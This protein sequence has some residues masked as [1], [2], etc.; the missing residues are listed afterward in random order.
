MANVLIA[1]LGESPV[2]VTAMYNLLTTDEKEREIG[3]IDKVVV[4]Y[5]EGDMIELGYD[6]VEEAFKGRCELEPWMLP[7]ED[8]NSEDTSYAFLR[9]LFQLLQVQQEC[10]NTVYLS[11]AGGRKNMSALMALVIPFFSCVKKLYHVIDQYEHKAGYAFKSIENL[12]ELN[13]TDRKLYLIPELNHLTLVDIPY[14]EHQHISNELRSRILTITEAQL[15]DLWEENVDEAEVLQ[16]YGSLT[17]NGTSKKAQPGKNLVGKILEV[18]V[19]EHVEKEYQKIC[20][21]DALRARK[22]ATCF[23][24]M[25]FADRFA[26]QFSTH[27]K[28]RDQTTLFHYYKRG[29][30]VERP[31]YHTEPEGIHRYP[32]ADVRR[33]IIS[34]LA[35]EV[36]DK[37]EPSEDVLRGLP[38]IPLVSIDALLPTECILLVPLGASPM[39]AT[40]LYTLLTSQ[41]NTVEEVILIYPEQSRAVNNSAGIARKAFADRGVKCRDVQVKGYDDLASTNACL[42]Y[43]KVLEATI[44]D[45]R[46][47]YPNYQIELSLSGGRKGMSALAMFAAQRKEIHYVYHTL[48]NDDELNRRIDY[49]TSIEALNKANKHV[50]NDRLFLRAYAKSDEELH[51]KF[52]LFKVPVLPVVK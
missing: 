4:L 17:K 21:R 9:L 8:A 51:E 20:G 38:L 36:E 31:F 28:I 50:R 44:D 11:L 40:Q 14:G 19:T 27:G 45:V 34:G 22:F 1:S 7:F 37:Y 49:E 24:Q 26:D 15:E 5:P 13:E 29:R 35:V 48:I 52:S 47:Q 6:L 46:I 2:V 3:K 43:Q 12:I 23:R 39:V 30:S 41:K 25:R 16:V 10:G 42:D 33:V 18:F 32:N